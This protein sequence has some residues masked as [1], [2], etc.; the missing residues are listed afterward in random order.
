MN[1]P[2]QLRDIQALIIDMDGVLWLDNT[3]LPGLVPFFD[4]LNR[5]SIPFILATNNASKTPNQYVDKLA[6]F[7]VTIGPEHVLTSPLATAAYLKHRYPP[8]TRVFA[9]G[10]EGI[11]EVM[12][13]AGFELVYDLS[14]PAEVVVAGV[15]FTLTYDKL[16]YATLHIQRG[17]HFV[18]T[19]GDLTFPAEEGPWPGAG[20]I[21]AAIQ[22]ATGVAP[23]TIGKPERLMFDIA[24]EKMGRDPGQT[25]MLGDRLETDILGGQQAGVKTILVTTGIDNETS[26]QLK[27]IYPDAI[28]SGLESLVAAWA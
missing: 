7:G 2:F 8:G 1:K 26:S 19:N 17:A 3:P 6:R 9:V 15:D 20:S 18:G 24:V 21:L 28:F 14:Q 22:A 16:K 10:Q 13:Q 5:R 4:F 27:G 12:R 25:A 23:V 11:L